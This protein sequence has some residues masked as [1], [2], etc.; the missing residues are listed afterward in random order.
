[1]CVCMYIYIYI[2]MYI[3]IYIYIYILNARKGI[4]LIKAQNFVSTSFS[5][6][7]FSGE[8]MFVYSEELKLQI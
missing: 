4:K 3:Y 8:M 5:Y 1:M 7:L 6:E 2:Y